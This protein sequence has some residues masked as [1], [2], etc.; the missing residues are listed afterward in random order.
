[1]R[2][3][4]D[5][6]SFRDRTH[7]LLTRDKAAELAAGRQTPPLSKHQSQRRR[8]GAAIGLRPGL[9]LLT[10]LTFA[11][12]AAVAVI[13]VVVRARVR[14]GGQAARRVRYADVMRDPVRALEQ[15]QHLEAQC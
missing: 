10:G 6:S 13:I 12:T 15:E 7:E 5:A 11:H 4:C 2:G 8:A 3:V 9:G 1:M 14:G